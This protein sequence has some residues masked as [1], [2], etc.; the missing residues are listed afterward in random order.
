MATIKDIAEKAG[1]SITT[2]SRV[3]NYDKTLSVSDAT[4]KKIFQVAESVSYTKNRRK[5]ATQNTIA[6][7]QWYT[8]AQELDDLYYLSIRMG[9]EKAAS[10]Q[11]LRI[12]QYFADNSLNDIGDVRGIIAIG[13]YSDDQIKKLT[14]KSNNIVFVDF[15]TL[16]LGYDCV[17]TDFENS[18]KKVIDH[19]ID[20]DI[21]NI[22]MLSGTETTS[23]GKLKIADPRAK[24]FKKYLVNKS[25]FKAQNILTADYTMDEAHDLVLKKLKE[26]GNEFPQALYVSNDAMAVGAE[27][28]LMESG[29]RIPDDVSI[30]SF[31]DTSIAKYV[32][33]AL[34]SV[35]V[36]TTRMGVLAINM[37][38]D[39]IDNDKQTTEKIIVSNELVIR[40]SSR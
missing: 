18:T 28:A 10:K 4:R 36:G 29:K 27:K 13:K 38:K 2:V 26:L 5:T 35:K 39:A 1:V 33:P 21:T 30:V 15:D 22:G 32:I 11:G 31:N 20:A 19:F 3:L 23:D 17:V 12:Q 16:A 37:V 9:A 34:S 6:I 8:E 24:I 25:L 14:K 7:V 40:E